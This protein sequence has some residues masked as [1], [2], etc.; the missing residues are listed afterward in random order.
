L[1]SKIV[2]MKI[3]DIRQSD[4]DA[5]LRAHHVTHTARE[6]FGHCHEVSSAWP[7]VPMNNARIAS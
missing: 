5:D 7:Q 6:V 3:D 1:A 2:I 4:D